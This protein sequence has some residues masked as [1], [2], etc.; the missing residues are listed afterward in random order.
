MKSVSE[1]PVGSRFMYDGNE[2]KVT[3]KRGTVVMARIIGTTGLSQVFFGFEMVQ[4]INE[5]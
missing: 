1:M 4:P 5:K 3:H 2:M